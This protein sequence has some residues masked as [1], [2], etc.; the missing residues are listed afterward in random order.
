MNHDA[1]DTETEVAVIVRFG[2]TD[3]YGVVYF[4][5]YFRYCHQGIEEFLRR[6]GLPPHEV[7]R[8]IDE[9]FGLPV[10]SAACDFLRPVRY[11]ETLRL[12]VSIREMKEKAIT[13]GFRFRRE[14]DP[15]VVAK[16]TA[17]IVAIGKDWR[18][19]RL[20]ERIAEALSAGDGPH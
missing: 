3:P 10:V 1:A 12:G 8:N 6:R 5:S 16:G 14:N 13:F 20:P 9:G 4:A 2:D 15:E 17:V 18:A 19:I 11:G 7:F